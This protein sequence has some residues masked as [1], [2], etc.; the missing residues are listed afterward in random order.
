MV[1]GGAPCGD[2]SGNLTGGYGPFAVANSDCPGPTTVMD[3]YAHHAVGQHVSALVGDAAVQSRT[4]TIWATTRTSTSA[5]T[6][7]RRGPTCWP[8]RRR[9]AVPRSSTLD[10]TA[11]AAG[12]SNVK[13][14]FHNYNA[15]LAWWWQV[16]NVLLG[17]LDCL[18]GTGGLVTGNV[19][20][21]ARAPA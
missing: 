1:E 8:S 12:H 17:Q 18:P 15:F 3:T 2:Y 19:T 20:S 21:L 7:D 9:P 4:T 13:A 6:A 11:L 10:I 16:D 14:R 5:T